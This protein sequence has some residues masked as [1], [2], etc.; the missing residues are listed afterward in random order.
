MTALTTFDDIIKDYIVGFR[1]NRLAEDRWFA[2]HRSLDD[3]IEN[4]AMAVSPS[5]KRLNHQRR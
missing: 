4:A 2:I 5:G 3:A 1:P